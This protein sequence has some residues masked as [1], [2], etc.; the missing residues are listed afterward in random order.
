MER[1]VSTHSAS[2]CLAFLYQPANREIAVVKGAIE[3]DRDISVYTNT[4]HWV[5][6]GEGQAA[7]TTR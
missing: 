5:T 2:L 3:A 1:I 4:H 7:L 6:G